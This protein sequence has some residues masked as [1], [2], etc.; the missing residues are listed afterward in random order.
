MMG[1]ALEAFDEVLPGA[2]PEAPPVPA[3]PSAE[4]VMGHAAGLAEG[5]AAGQARAEAASATLSAELAQALGDAAFGFAEARAQVLG[6]L[7][8][9]VRAVLDALLPEAAALSLAPRVAEA[10][11]EAASL[12][13][14]A[15]VR[16][17][18]HP[19]RLEAVRA[20]L[21]AN[22]PFAL[23]ADARLGPHAA[24]IG[25]R[26]EE[27]AL[28]LDACLAALTE[29]LAPLLDERLARAP[30]LPARAG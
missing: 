21:P 13:S 26:A 30:V 25:T 28:D 17:C 14:A 8:P 27:T 9:L 23:R 4:W 11:L 16:V 29:A 7:R 24:E 6:S 12:D 10:V 2:F 18:V 1:L 15:P 22:G 20:C 19:S 5:L 3:G